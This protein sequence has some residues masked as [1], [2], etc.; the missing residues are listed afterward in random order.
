RRLL[1]QDN[2][3]AAFGGHAAALGADADGEPGALH[4][5]RAGRAPVRADQHAR[6]V[7]GRD[8]RPGDG[9]RD[10][11]RP[12]PAPLRPPAGARRGGAGGGERVAL[13][14][15][16]GVTNAIDRAHR[17]LGDCTLG[18]VGLGSIGREVARRAL[19]FSMRV[20]A[21]DAQA[22]APAPDGV[23]ALWPVARLADLL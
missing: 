5:R 15:G 16:P 17:H 8:R 3:G 20:L 22:S 7:L 1:R 18:V 12:P 4:V 23:E 9:L 2:T 13:R 11:L 6:A 21:V 14:A 10:L 19:A